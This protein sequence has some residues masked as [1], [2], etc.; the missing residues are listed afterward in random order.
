MLGSIIEV[1]VELVS[2]LQTNKV[3]NSFTFTIQKEKSKFET[4][5]M[6]NKGSVPV[7]VRLV[8]RI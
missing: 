6:N 3:P 8:I 5:V 7:L 2:F 1:Y 4:K